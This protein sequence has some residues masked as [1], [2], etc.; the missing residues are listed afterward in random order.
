[1]ADVKLIPL[2]VKAVQELSEQNKQ[3]AEEINKLKG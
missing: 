3:L 1:M 2:L